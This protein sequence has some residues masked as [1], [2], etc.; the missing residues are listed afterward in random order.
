MAPWYCWEQNGVIIQIRLQPRAR[1]D[2]IAGL[3]GEWLKIR[4]TAPPVEGKAN[5]HLLKFLARSFQ[6]SKS[7][8]RL[9][10]GAT[11]R[12][13]RVYIENPAKLLPGMELL[14]RSVASGKQPRAET[15]Q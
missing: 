11:S 9:L 8:V 5:A 6:V 2:E 1:C 12:N 15:A 3:Q 7:Q 13:K 4:I 14:T 10:S